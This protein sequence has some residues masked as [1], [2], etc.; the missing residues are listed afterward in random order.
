MVK[1]TERLLKQALESLSMTRHTKA[2]RFIE[3]AIKEIT[4]KKQQQQSSQ[5]EFNP[6]YGQMIPSDPAIAKR[7]LDELDKNIKKNQLELDKSMGNDNS[8]TIFG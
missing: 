4:P 1:N 6:S 2:K 7:I 8:E 3:M 5:W